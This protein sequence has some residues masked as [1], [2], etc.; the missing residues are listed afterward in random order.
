MQVNARKQTPRRNLGDLKFSDMPP[1][2]F[3]RTDGRIGL[4]GLDPIQ[5]A[6][7]VANQ[8]TPSSHINYE[9]RER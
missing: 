5:E 4:V 9:D 2:R 8:A 3:H 7:E 6:P 1:A